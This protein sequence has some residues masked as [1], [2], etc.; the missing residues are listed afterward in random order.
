MANPFLFVVLL[1]GALPIA[2]GASQAADGDAP[3]ALQELGLGKL[4]WHMSVTEARQAS[5]LF[6]SRRTRLSKQSGKTSLL[7]VNDYPL[8]G[9]RFSLKMRFDSKGLNSIALGG[10]SG[11]QPPSTCV[12]LIERELLNRF[13]VPQ[14]Y[15]ELDSPTRLSFRWRGAFGIVDFKPPTD[16]RILPLV[17]L[18]A[19]QTRQ[20]AEISVLGLRLDRL[21]WDMPIDQV[22]QYFPMQRLNCSNQIGWRFRSITQAA[23]SAC[24][25]ISRRMA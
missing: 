9:C 15:L 18:T 16:D 17:E 23:I 1:I 3:L 7:E 22:K 20:I 10:S 5:P 12:P 11:H 6:D 13:G 8:A 25:S 14:R 2:W 4:H 24:A 21:R 19:P